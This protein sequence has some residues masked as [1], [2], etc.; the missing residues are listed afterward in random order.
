[1][2]KAST[3][4]TVCVLDN[5]QKTSMFC[6]LEA[7]AHSVTLGRITVRIC[8]AQSEKGYAAGRCFNT[9]KS[10][11]TPFKMDVRR[12]KTMIQGDEI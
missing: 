5:F 6:P 4:L 10:C 2:A 3:I 9:W 12:I 11:G 7:F 8:F 1:M